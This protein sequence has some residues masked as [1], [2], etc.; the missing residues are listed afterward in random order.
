[1]SGPGCG[2]LA[3]KQPYL[4]PVTI[5]R[6]RDVALYTIAAIRG[7]IHAFLTSFRAC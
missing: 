3:A 4:T 5:R 2:S 6:Q 7:S 1:V